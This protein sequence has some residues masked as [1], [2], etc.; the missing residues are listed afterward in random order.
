[1]GLT[2]TF[3]KDSWY[4]NTFASG[5]RRQAL[6]LLRSPRTLLSPVTEPFWRVQWVCGPRGPAQ[7]RQA[8]SQE[9]RVPFNSP[10]FPSP[11]TWLSFL[12]QLL[13]TR[14][15]SLPPRDVP[16]S[17]VCGRAWLPGT[18][19]P[20]EAPLS[21]LEHSLLRLSVQFLLQTRALCCALLWAVCVE[22]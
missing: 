11:F 20:W 12:H 14:A 13:L 5:I 1:M 3:L 8:C 18:T 19:S 22:K 16:S 4:R 2:S 21:L 15:W 7:P 10:C 6:T 9:P 17:R